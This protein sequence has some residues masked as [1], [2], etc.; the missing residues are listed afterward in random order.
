MD[1]MHVG[2]TG[3]PLALLDIW[4]GLKGMAVGGGIVALYFIIKTIIDAR[5]EKRKS[6]PG[7]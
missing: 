6:A 1:W 2:S 5:R 3:S 7:A 4:D